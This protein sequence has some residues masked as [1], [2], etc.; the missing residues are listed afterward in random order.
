MDYKSWAV[1]TEYV[2]IYMYIIYYVYAF[3]L[4]HKHFLKLNRNIPT[5]RA[6]RTE[7]FRQVFYHEIRRRNRTTS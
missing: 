6:L 7:P 5:V 4:H 2:K 1:P 3:H